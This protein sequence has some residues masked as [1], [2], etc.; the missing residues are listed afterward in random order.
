MI[1]FSFLYNLKIFFFNVCT[2]FFPCFS[3]LLTNKF[4]EKYNDSI[5]MSYIFIDFSFDILYTSQMIK[6]NK[7]DDTR[8]T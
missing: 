2:I 5:E 8:N 6:V 4:F 1:N 7:D 3:I